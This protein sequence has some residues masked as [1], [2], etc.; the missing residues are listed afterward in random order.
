[1][2][3]LACGLTVALLATMAATAFYL[4]I[5]FFYSFLF[6]AIPLA[7]PIVFGRETAAVSEL[8]KNRR[9]DSLPQQVGRLA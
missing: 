5:S 4:T 2:R 6:V 3:R 1:V 7:T 8:D 9:A